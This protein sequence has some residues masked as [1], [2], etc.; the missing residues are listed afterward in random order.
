MP[1]KNLASK[2]HNT[3]NR[4]R[5]RNKGRE[6]LSAAPNSPLTSE[7]SPN[8]GSPAPEGKHPPPATETNTTTTT[9]SVRSHQL[10]HPPDYSLKDSVT[11][12]SKNNAENV[13]K[14]NKG[15]EDGSPTPCIAVTSKVSDN[16]EASIQTDFPSEDPPVL[17]Q[18]S[19]LANLTSEL[20]AIRS[21]M[22]KLDKIEL[23]ISTLVSQFGGLADRT[24]K[25]ETKVDSHDSKLTEISTEVASLRETVDLQ[26]RA[27]AKL[28]SMKSDLLKK[29]KEVEA[30][31]VKK[32]KGITKEMNQL[33]DQQKNQ[34]ESFLSTTK[35]I[36]TNIYERV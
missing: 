4:S 6:P 17:L 30:D 3:R 16:K 9:T 29:N 19:A 18:A 24:G 33:I 26:G 34:V 15:Q 8:D 2:D 22:D 28:T 27:L 13:T 5:S 20:T 10:D 21:R 7:S 11:D 1:P 14:I 25:L 31:L 23:S 12:M 32:N 35:R 36:E